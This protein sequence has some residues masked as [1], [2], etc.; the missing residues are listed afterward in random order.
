MNI[1]RFIRWVIDNFFVILLAVNS[2]LCVYW[3]IISDDPPIA[4]LIY[5]TVFY[6]LWRILNKHAIL[7]QVFSTITI[8]LLVLNGVYLLSFMPELKQVASYNGN[9]YFLTYNREFLGNG[10]F[11]P[12]LAKWDNKFHRSISGLGATCCTLRLTY[13]PLSHLVSVEQIGLEDTPILAYTDS[14]PPRFYVLG[15]HKQFDEYR[16]Y[17]SRDCETYQKNICQTHIYNVYRCSLENTACVPL[18]FKYL[19]DYA[20]EIEMSQNEQTKEINIYFWIGDYPGVQTLIFT[21]GNNPSCHVAGC[22]L[23]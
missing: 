1:N 20:F 22:Q 3:Y 23:H 7:R 15:A 12:R 9:T 4:L 17:P 13:D 14:D 6:L 16:Y 8:L 19:G 21:Y 10:V 11:F 2:L 18:P 5:S